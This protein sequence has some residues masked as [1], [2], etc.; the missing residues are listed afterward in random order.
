MES[1]NCISCGVS[2]NS[3]M[4]YKGS[5]KCKECVISRVAE[6]RLAKKQGTLPSKSQQTRDKEIRDLQVTKT[7]PN[8]TSLLSMDKFYK[9]TGGYTTLCKKC[10]CSN[11]AE[12][13]LN[14][15]VPTENELLSKDNLKRCSTCLE[16]K[17]TNMF[18]K[19]R[20]SLESE[21]KVCKHDK[22]SYRFANDPSLSVAASVRRKEYLKENPEAMARSVAY[23]AKYYQE[24][25]EEHDEWCR[26][27]FKRN[28]NAQYGYFRKWRLANL[29]VSRFHANKR[30]AQKL[31]ATP[32]WSCEETVKSIYLEALAKQE[33]FGEVFHVDHIVP[34]QS[35]FVCG[36]HCQYN[37]QIL[38]KA[39]N[40]IKGNRHWPDMW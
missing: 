23:S 3:D 39:E 12:Q 4:Y 37:L 33:K 24:N 16:V 5:N 25:K 10:T 6:V 29:D 38:T 36:L 34:L 30:R 21:C 17:G 11:A 35:E 19:K 9:K 31:S 27:W 13:R 8:C 7:C 22:K 14:I 26:G 18:H 2:K 28:P 20:D 15:R 32:S 40:L 1:K